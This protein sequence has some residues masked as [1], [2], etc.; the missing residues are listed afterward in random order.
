MCQQSSILPNP[1]AIPWGNSGKDQKVVGLNFRLRSGGLRKGTPP[2]SAPIS[3][4]KWRQE[5][6]LSPWFTGWIQWKVGKT[7][8]RG[9]GPSWEPRNQHLYIKREKHGLQNEIWVPIP[10][11]PTQLSRSKLLRSYVSIS[12]LLQYM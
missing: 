1:P 7:T 4:I 3:P 11:V 5:C 6:R 10:D 2:L 9:S 12:S 8:C